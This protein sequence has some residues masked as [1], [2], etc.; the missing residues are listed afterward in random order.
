MRGYL[1][2]IATGPEMSRD[3][4]LE[5]AREGLRLILEGRAHPV[6]AG[7]FLIALRMKRESDDE[8]RGALEAVRA[9]TR[10]AE[11]PVDDLVDLADPYDGFA[12]SLPA[13]PFLP[14][15]L[16]ALGLPVVSH[17]LE[18]VGPKGGLTPR[19]VLRAA[20]VPVDLT[21]ERAAARVADPDT[22]WAYV[23]QSVFCP[24]LHALVELRELIVKRP[25]ITTV[26]RLA[27]PVR[28]RGRTHLAIGYVHAP[29]PRIYGL[30]AAHAG[31]A[32]GLF[33]R[34]VEGGV[35]PSLRQ[36]GHYHAWSGAG[37]AQPVEVDPG[38]LAIEGSSRAPSWPAGLEMPRDAQAIAERAA[39]AGGA[40]LGG[41]PGPAREALVYAAALV[42]HGLGRAP[43]LAEAASRARAALDSGAA[44]ERFER[45]RRA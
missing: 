8:H 9:A 35:V 34:G 40:A 27:G 23:D 11:A 44:R 15:L 3:L 16:A 39:A 7:V 1:Q 45:G 2:R 14:A 41:E 18:R 19:A 31:F 32:S 17:G 37:A 12:R 4:S 10:A 43:S 29:Y 24:E 20:G 28:A 38:S 25:V 42:L 6:Q 13:S 33:V 21:P 5:E 36:K 26:E 22:G 30:L